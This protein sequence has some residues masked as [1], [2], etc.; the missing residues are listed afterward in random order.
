MRRITN[1][2]VLPRY[3]LEVEFDDGVSG[4][5]DI[6]DNVGKGVFALWLDPFVFEQV[7]NRASFYQK[8]QLFLFFNSEI[9]M[10]N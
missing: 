10:R 9:Q 8:Q 6:S 5:V 1:V 3:R 7:R 4:I 2:N